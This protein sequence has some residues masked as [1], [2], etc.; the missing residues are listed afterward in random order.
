QFCS[1]SDSPKSASGAACS[2][3]EQATAAQRYAPMQSRF[4]LLMPHIV[5]EYSNIPPTIAP[6]RLYPNALLAAPRPFRTS[7]KAIA[8]KK[9][10]ITKRNKEMKRFSRA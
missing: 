1:A 9:I 4:R 8:A 3:L 10:E 6:K 5:E 7:A 2:L